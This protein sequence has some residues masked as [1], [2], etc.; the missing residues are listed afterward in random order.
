MTWTITYFGKKPTLRKPTL[1]EGLPGIGN[2]GKVAV[3]FMIEELD[4]K[5]IAT[6]NGTMPHSVFV[7]EDNLVELP[8]I[9][10]YHKRINNKDYLFIAGDTQPSDEAGCYAF[11]NAVLNE[12]QE[13]KAHEVITL[14][15]IALREEPQHPQGTTSILDRWQSSYRL[16]KG[17]ADYQAD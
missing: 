16:H 10:L 15:G 5:K 3:D 13:L 8:S 6:I 17:Q 1:I 2:V 9:N 4:A 12:L 7:N 11:C 14:G